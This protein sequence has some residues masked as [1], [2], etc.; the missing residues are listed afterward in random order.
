[1]LHLAFIMLQPSPAKQVIR[2]VV[3]RLALRVNERVNDRAH[4]HLSK[5]NLI[6]VRGATWVSVLLSPYHFG[7]TVVY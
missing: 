4:T 2:D 7:M 1:M 3:P 5:W 6:L